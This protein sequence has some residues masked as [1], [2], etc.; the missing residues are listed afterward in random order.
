MGYWWF[1]SYVIQYTKCK[2]KQDED[3]SCIVK[4]LKIKYTSG[5]DKGC[6]GLLLKKLLLLLPAPFCF[7]WPAC[8]LFSQTS[9]LWGS[10]SGSWGKT[11]GDRRKTGGAEGPFLKGII[12]VR[13]KD[14]YDH[15]VNRLGGVGVR[16]ESG[17]PF[18]TAP[19][20]VLRSI[21]AQCWEG[22][23]HWWRTVL[24][25]H[26]CLCEVEL[27]PSSLRGRVPPYL[28]CRMPWV[29]SGCLMPWLFDRGSSEG[30]DELLRPD[31]AASQET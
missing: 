28:C 29:P 18:H 8:R 2:P 20:Q 12:T 31:L 10:A 13:A 26:C 16:E 21:V 17:F 6:L 25:M 19:P 9:F 27:D 3:K 7:L 23:K 11:A 24:R 22:K 4:H 5:C 14:V 15:S 30:K 1:M